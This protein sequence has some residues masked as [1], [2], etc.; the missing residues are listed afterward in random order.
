[1][2]SSSSEPSVSSI[3]SMS[4]IVGRAGEDIARR[5]WASWA[6]TRFSTRSAFLMASGVGSKVDDLKTC[7]SP[8][9]TAFLQVGP[10]LQRASIDAKSIKMR[11]NRADIPLLQ[12][13]QTLAHVH[14]RDRCAYVSKKKKKWTCC[15]QLTV[16]GDWGPA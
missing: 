2:G 10:D 15:S 4:A 5:F 14:H 1:M 7:L 6:F 9:S 16:V 13:P 3:M 12:Q 8:K 11:T